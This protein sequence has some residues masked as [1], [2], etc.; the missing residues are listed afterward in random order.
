MSLFGEM[1]FSHVVYGCVYPELR[2]TVGIAGCDMLSIWAFFLDDGV[3]AAFLGVSRDELRTHISGCSGW[4]TKVV[5]SPAGWGPGW[6][7][8]ELLRGRV[9]CGQHD[10][11]YHLRVPVT[12]IHGNFNRWGVRRDLIDRVLRAR[13]V[14][15]P[16]R[17]FAVQHLRRARVPRGDVGHQPSPPE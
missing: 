15:K 1:F 11:R 3:Y 17:L 5:L 2:T 7:R 8:Y 12:G 9:P 13:T 16:P 10:V 6:E 14:S 4:V